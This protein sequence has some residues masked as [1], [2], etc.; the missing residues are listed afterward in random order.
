[1][2]ANGVGGSVDHRCD[3]TS[4]LGGRHEAGICIFPP[5]ALRMDGAETE[6]KLGA[7]GI[8]RIH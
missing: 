3:Y 4:Q 2:A 7:R 8:V 5:S 1:M 6:G